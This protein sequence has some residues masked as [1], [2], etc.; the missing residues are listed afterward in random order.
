M[1]K[2]NLLNEIKSDIIDRLNERIGN[3]Y[4]LCDL[5]MELTEGE[6]SNG[7]WFCNTYKA[8]EHLKENIETVDEFAEWYQNNFGEDG[9][10]AKFLT[11]PELFHCIFMIFCVEN[12]FN[13]AVSDMSNEKIEITEEFIE[14]VKQNLNNVNSVF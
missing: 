9:T 4:Y 3:D 11:E 14:T 8:K 7:S 1:K 2:E 5:G 13:Q 10:L 12:V 6:N